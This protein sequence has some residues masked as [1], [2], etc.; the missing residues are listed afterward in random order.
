MP[1][2]NGG[3]R[4]APPTLKKLKGMQPCRVNSEAPV[5][6]DAQGAPPD[7]LSPEAVDVWWRTVPE[8]KRLH[9][10]NVVEVTQLVCYCEAVIVHREAVKDVREYGITILGHMGGRVKNPAWNVQ[11]EAAMLV[12]AFAIEFGLTPA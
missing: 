2:G 8:L 9:L 4:P 1:R 12:R 11:R 3:Q 6:A 5:L 10:L 7:E